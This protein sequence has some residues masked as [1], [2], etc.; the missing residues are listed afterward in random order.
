[1]HPYGIGSPLLLLSVHG[2][3]VQ[4]WGMPSSLKRL[5]ELLELE[6]RKSARKGTPRFDSKK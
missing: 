5:F 1:V 3:S 2:I 4:V 6:N